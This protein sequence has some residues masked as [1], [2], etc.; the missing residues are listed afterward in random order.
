MPSTQKADNEARWD[1]RLAE[2]TEYRA[3]GNDWPRHKGFATEEERVL[4]VWLHVQ[5]I[6]LRD[7][8]LGVDRLERLDVSVPGWR[9]G[10]AAAAG[11]HR[12]AKRP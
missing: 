1:R 12:S 5:R 2:L 8:K 9:A 6:S 4:G 10:R 11:R 3:A 7:G